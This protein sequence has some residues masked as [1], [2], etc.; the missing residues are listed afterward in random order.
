M[1]ITKLKSLSIALKSET[2]PD[3]KKIILQSLINE[4]AI[5]LTPEAKLAVESINKK[6]E[7]TRGH[8]DDY[9]ALL[10]NFKD[11]YRLAFAKSLIDNGGSSKGI[12]DALNLLSGNDNLDHNII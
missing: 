7:T 9:M 12:N 10:G 1:D 11:M 5:L 4:I 3:K 2:D 8:Y 6:I